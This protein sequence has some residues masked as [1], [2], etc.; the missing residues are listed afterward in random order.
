MIRL[1]QRDQPVGS[2]HSHIEGTVAQ[3]GYQLIQSQV[4][5]GSGGIFGLYSTVAA[6]S[7]WSPYVFIHEFGHHFAG[8]ADEYYT[9]DVAYE[10]AAEIVE[11]WEMNVTAHPH[12]AAVPGP[13]RG[14]PGVPGSPAEGGSG[15]R[16]VGPAAGGVGDRQYLR[17]VRGPGSGVRDCEHGCV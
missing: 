16:V 8:L 12:R 13:G 10:P 4:A 2:R 7:L 17:C 3:A 9:S 15:S 14:P 11:P 6:D 5:I 1:G